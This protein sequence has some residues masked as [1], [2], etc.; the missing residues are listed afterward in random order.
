M[1]EQNGTRLPDRERHSFVSL[2][3]AI[4]AV[5]SE[6]RIDPH[7]RGFLCGLLISVCDS[8]AGAICAD[9]GGHGRSV[10]Q[11]DALAEHLY[12]HAGR[13]AAGAAGAGGG[14]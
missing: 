5:L 10:D 14:R 3:D 6:D 4:A 11:L 9:V 8:A 1:A 12:A 13:L 2:L 7:G